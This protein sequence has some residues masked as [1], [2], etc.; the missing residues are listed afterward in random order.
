[1]ARNVEIKA[2]VADLDAIEARARAIA[3]SGPED[4]VQ[5]DTFFACAQGRLKLRQFGDGRGELIHYRRADDDGPKVS[6]YILVPSTDPEAL[7]EALSRAIGVGGRVRKQRRLYLLDRTRIHLDRVE[8]LGT[9]VELEVVLDEGE[10]VAAGEA[11]AR[12]VMQRLRIRPEQLV[13]G[14]YVDMA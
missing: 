2:R 4:I 6:D 9:F 1:M 14:A 8:G 3:T 7:R 13:R 11:V 5:D 12:D 10:S